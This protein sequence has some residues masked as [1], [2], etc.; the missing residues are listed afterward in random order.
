VRRDSGLQVKQQPKK[1]RLCT[2]GLFLDWRHP[3]LHITYSFCSGK[4]KYRKLHTKDHAIDKSEQ[5]LR[6]HWLTRYASCAR[7][8]S[9]Q[10]PD[11]QI[12][13]FNGA[14]NLPAPSFLTQGSIELRYFFK[15]NANISPFACSCKL[16]MGRATYN[17]NLNLTIKS[18]VPYW[19]T[20]KCRFSTA[21][22]DY[23][24][25]I[26][27]LRKCSG[28]FS[29]GPVQSYLLKNKKIFT[30]YVLGLSPIVSPSL[31]YNC[32]TTS[33][34]YLQALLCCFTLCYKDG[35][36]YNSFNIHSSALLRPVMN[37]SFSLA[38]KT[39]CTIRV[40]LRPSIGPLLKLYLLQKTF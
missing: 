4:F 12:F 24:Q 30:F 36:R 34:D 33:I 39:R 23:D 7:G 10:V 17:R 29:K 9:V 25:E 18:L 11:L 26:P 3:I 20:R 40:R 8:V 38:T 2:T 16:T 5:P 37:E 22:A 14:N 13:L 28:F 21:G 1:Q 6:R 15:Q 19:V 27:E 31:I 35:P 32:F